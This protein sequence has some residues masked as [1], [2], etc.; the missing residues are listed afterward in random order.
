M[1]AFKHF[2]LWQINPL[3]L[4]PWFIWILNTSD[5]QDGDIW[6]RMFESEKVLEAV[7][8]DLL[9]SPAGNKSEE[10]ALY[11]ITMALN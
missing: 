5:I 4:Q 6:H 1:K 2:L 7:V 10:S 11:G 8:D 9:P 3:N